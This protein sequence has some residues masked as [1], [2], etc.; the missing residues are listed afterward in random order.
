[1]KVQFCTSMLL[2]EIYAYEHQ[3]LASYISFQLLNLSIYEFMLDIACKFWLCIQYLCT[4][5]Y[6]S[7]ARN[8]VG[9]FNLIDSHWYFKINNTFI[10]TSY[11]KT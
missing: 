11:V 10:R 1:M 8:K 3:L 7:D 2:T 5:R 4:K 9:G 6:Y